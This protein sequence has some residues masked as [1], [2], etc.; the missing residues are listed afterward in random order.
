MRWRK[1]E[2]EHPNICAQCLCKTLCGNYITCVYKLFKDSTD[3]FPWHCV[4]LNEEFSDSIVE[5]WIPIS[6]INELCKEES[7]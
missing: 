1:S 4:M 7:E 2:N 6:E 3:E 5:Q